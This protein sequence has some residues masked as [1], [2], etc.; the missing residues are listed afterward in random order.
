MTPKKRRK[1]EKKE[2]AMVDRPC[3]ATTAVMEA[4]ESYILAAAIL[5]NINHYL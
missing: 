4:I 1:N 5:G 2:V 3:A